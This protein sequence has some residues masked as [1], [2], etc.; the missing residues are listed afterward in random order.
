MFSNEPYLYNWSIEVGDREFM[1]TVLHDG[2]MRWQE[3]GAIQQAGGERYT[4]DAIG[5]FFGDEAAAARTPQ[6]VRR[7][8]D[9]HPGGRHRNGA[10]SA[11]GNIGRR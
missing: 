1:I 9:Q 4:C 11:C 6:P 10:F 3:L 5:A 8:S 2:S 7:V